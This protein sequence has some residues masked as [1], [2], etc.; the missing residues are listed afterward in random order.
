M[1][2]EEVA[3]HHKVNPNSLNTK[4]DALKIGIKSV[5]ELVQIMEKRQVDRETI[6]DIKRLG[7]FFQDVTQTTS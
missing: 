5:K 6:N 1:T 2:L 7:L 3:I 4:D